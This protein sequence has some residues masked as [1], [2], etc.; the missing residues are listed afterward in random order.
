VTFGGFFE[1]ARW[2]VVEGIRAIPDFSGLY[3]VDV[4]LQTMAPLK[5][6]QGMSETRDTHGHAM[7]CTVTHTI[8]YVLHVK[9]YHHERLVYGPNGL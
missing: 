2:S 8:P 7:A 5:C 4:I 3:A 1:I 6:S 9:T